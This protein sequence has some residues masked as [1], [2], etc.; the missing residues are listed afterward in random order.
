MDP[1]AGSAHLPTPQA[2]YQEGESGPSGDNATRNAERAGGNDVVEIIDDNDV[3]VI[4]GTAKLAVCAF[5]HLLLET[6]NQRQMR[7]GYDEHMDVV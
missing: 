3:E 7:F 4:R 5:L 2:A 6:R 1:A